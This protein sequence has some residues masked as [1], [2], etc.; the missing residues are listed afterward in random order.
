[1]DWL[2]YIGAFVV[3]FVK[4]YLIVLYYLSISRGRAV[5]GSGLSLGIWLVDVVVIL[6]MVKISLFLC[7]P[8]GI[9]TVM[10]TYLC[11]KNHRG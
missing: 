11:I 4:E 9:G 7:V 2:V 6:S 5:L 10:G 8:Y 3:S 1:M